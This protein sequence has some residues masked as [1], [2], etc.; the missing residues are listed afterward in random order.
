MYFDVTSSS[1]NKNPYAKL[2][3]VSGEGT[4]NMTLVYDTDADN[5]TNTAH[6]YK[7]K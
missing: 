5:G 2:T 1:T 4:A 6:L 7:I 3:T